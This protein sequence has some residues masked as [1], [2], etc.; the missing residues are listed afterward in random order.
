MLNRNKTSLEELLRSKLPAELYY[1]Y[2][3]VYISKPELRFDKVYMPK[4]KK[5]FQ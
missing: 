5:N 3:H 1:K 2:C 4:V